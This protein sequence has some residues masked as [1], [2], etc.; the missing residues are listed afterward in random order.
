MNIRSIF[1]ATLLVAT[2]VA[3]S[4]TPAPSGPPTSP[5]DP[6]SAYEGNCFDDGG[7]GVGG[8]RYLGPQNRRDNAAIYLSSSTGDPCDGIG[9]LTTLVPAA[10]LTRAEAR[11]EAQL[12]EPP[13]VVL[14]LNSA[15]A[16][17]DSWLCVV[18]AS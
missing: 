13:F 16:P 2:P 4:C 6:W 18:I 12:G 15:G 17:P 10:D 1:A 8:I 3:A 14:P 9:A 11:C 5:S 7:L